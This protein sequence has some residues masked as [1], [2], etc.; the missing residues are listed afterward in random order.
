MAAGEAGGGDAYD[1]PAGLV[2]CVGGDAH[3]GGGVVVSVVKV[4]EVGVVKMVMVL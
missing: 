1:V 4:V 2:D 3:L